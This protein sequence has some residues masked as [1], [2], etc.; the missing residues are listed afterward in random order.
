MPLEWRLMI[1]Q[2]DLYELWLEK[3]LSGLSAIMK[4]PFPWRWRRLKQLPSIF[5]S[6]CY[7]FIP[8]SR[9]ATRS[10]NHL[11]STLE[12]FHQSS[13]INS[14]SFFSYYF[15]MTTLHCTW[16]P[17]FYLKRVMYLLLETSSIQP[18][19]FQQILSLT[20]FF[21]SSTCQAI[22]HRIGHCLQSCD[23]SR[24]PDSTIWRYL[25]KLPSRKL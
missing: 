4:H 9:C 13:S 17:H 1:G 12:I 8:S 5:A 10:L 18:R 23:L 15:N 25:P 24:H 20:R 6:F 2:L 3:F 16:P 11:Q 21:R 14:S 22:C 7:R 19:A